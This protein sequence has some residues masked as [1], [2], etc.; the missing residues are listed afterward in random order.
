MKMLVTLKAPELLDIGT[1]KYGV[2]NYQWHLRK[3]LSRSFNHRPDKAFV[4]DKDCLIWYIKYN[5]LEV[6][7]SFFFEKHAIKKF[8]SSIGL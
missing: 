4:D 1:F 6:D 3:A 5:Q 2:Q 8:F 7:I